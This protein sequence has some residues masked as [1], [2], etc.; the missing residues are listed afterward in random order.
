MS[1]NEKLKAELLEVVLKMEMQLKKFEDKRLQKQQ[2]EQEIGSQLVDKDQKIR[3][4]QK[5][6]KQLKTE[7]QTMWQQLEHSYNIELINKLEDDLKDKT[8]KL[9]QLKDET[10]SLHKV[11]KEQ[12]GALEN[13]N[14]NKENSAKMSNLS[15]QLK[16]MKQQFKEMRELQ[17]EDNKL[18]KN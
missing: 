12:K 9:N 8:N 10:N 11:G 3:V 16:I 15:N 1:I 18:I 6:F 17:R 13:L 2:Q 14:R 5:K 4:G 7:V